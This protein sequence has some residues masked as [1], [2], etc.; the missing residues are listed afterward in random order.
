M[1]LTAVEKTSSD[2]L[3]AKWSAWSIG[4]HPVIANSA[5]YFDLLQ[6]VASHVTVSL[7]RQS[8]LVNAGYAARMASLAGT[9]QQ[10]LN[11][12]CNHHPVDIVVLGCG[13]DTLGLWI[14]SLVENK[15]NVRIIEIDTPQVCASKRKILTG[16]GLLET[17]ELE[18]DSDMET[19]RANIRLS[20]ICEGEQK[21]GAST[22]DCY[23]LLSGDLR[24]V[25]W[26]DQALSFR[27]QSPPRPTLAILEL[28]LAYLGEANIDRLLKFS[29]TSL[30]ATTGSALVALEPLGPDKS[31]IVQPSSCGVS[32]GQ[33]YREEY[34]RQF[35]AKL[36]RGVATSP[37]ADQ[38]DDSHLEANC[39]TPLGHSSQSV[40]DRF[41]AAGFRYAF[42]CSLGVSA[43]WA[44]SRWGAMLQ[45]P[46]PFD[47]H[48]ALLL[49]LSSY[50]LVC[51]FIEQHSS[52]EMQR[53][54]C[55]WSKKLMTTLYV[56]PLKIRWVDG[57]NNNDGVYTIS[58]IQSH[59]EDE[60]V[61]GMFRNTYQD[62]FEDYPAVKKLVKSAIK[63][64]LGIERGVTGHAA[65]RSSIGVRYR[66]LG[67]IFVVAT[68]QADAEGETVESDW[69]RVVG[70]AGIRVWGG[71]DQKSFEIQRLAVDETMRGKGIGGALLKA[72][73][74]SL[75]TI[76]RP[77]CQLLATT[78]D[79]LTSANALYTLNGYQ[80]KETKK[81]SN[82]TMNTYSK[83]I[84]A[85]LT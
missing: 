46:E 63:S 13:L 62:L 14:Y 80:L 28:V 67:G 9:V 41:Q 26:L 1:S 56:N 21:G 69:R 59:H 54:M 81:I 58:E 15:D 53:I 40:E 78:P 32:V 24:N 6:Q 84:Q 34:C 23:V 77:R 66:S 76:F 31:K 33:L 37:S 27:Q 16:L 20:G 12:H 51:G 85:D 29:A 48:A 44:Q 10:F 45:A 47:E 22:S 8:P 57:D 72:I 70:F 64:D 5:I 7:K 17:R 4:Y 2:A 52:M 83:L 60:Q 36:A 43:A 82:L 11:Y 74:T 50:V 49:H 39:F 71:V 25:D 35:Q 79:I 3:H 68:V 30:C 38:R 73:E 18:S 61:R 65:N 75:K 55:G 19:F 42:S